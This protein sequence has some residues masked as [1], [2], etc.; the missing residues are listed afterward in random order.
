MGMKRE[1]RI[2][3]NSKE[4]LKRISKGHFECLMN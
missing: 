4:E 2:C 1:D 3:V